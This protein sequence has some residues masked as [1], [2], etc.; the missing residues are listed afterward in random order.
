MKRLGLLLLIIEMLSACSPI[1]SMQP[2]DHQQAAI[3]LQQF[4]TSRPSKQSITIE[5]PK[6]QKWKKVD[7]SL[8]HKGAPILLIPEED[9]PFHWHESIQTKIIS[10]QNDPTVTAKSLFLKQETLLQ[11]YCQIAHTSLREE[12]AVAVYF[13]SRATHCENSTDLFIAGKIFNGEDGVYMVYYS[14]R[15]LPTDKQI[16]LMTHVIASAELVAN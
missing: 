5:L 8:N 2:F 14:A 13:E 10:Y 1:N 9:S 3:L 16:T 6:T 12:N 7:L 15:Y 4:E 11:A